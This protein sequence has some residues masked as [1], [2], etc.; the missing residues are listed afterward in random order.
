MVRSALRSAEQDWT[1]RISM[2]LDPLVRSRLL[3]LI[4]ADAEAE[5]DEDGAQD[6]DTVLGLIKSMPGNVSL[7]SIMTEIS[8][9]G[10]VRA[11]GL[12]AGLFADVAPKVLDSWRARAAV[13]APSHLRR[14]ADPLTLTF[15]IAEAALEKPDD[16]VRAVSSRR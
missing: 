7:E 15:S 8:K 12:P 14:H 2:R 6:S 16:A 5:V 4:D 1:L 13:E 3:G 9:L 11:V 10:A